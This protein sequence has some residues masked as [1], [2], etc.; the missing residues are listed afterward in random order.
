MAAEPPVGV[1]GT[2]ALGSVLANRL[3]AGG[4]PTC[5]YDADPGAYAA[6]APEVEP[7]PS[8]ADVARRAE[9]V[10]TC[11]TNAAAVEQAVLGPDGVVEGI[12]AG[13][14]LIET[15]TSTPATTRLLAGPLR[16]AGADLIDAPVSR[17][18][19]AALAGTLSIW[20]GGDAGTLRR[21]RPLLE[22]LGTDILHV[23]DLGAGHTVKAVNMLLMGINLA[24]LTEAA[25][26]ARRYGLELDR[27]LEVLN[28]S[29]GGSFMSASHFPRYVATGTY[30]SR[31]TLG[32]MLKDL[33]VGL[34]I[35]RD[36]GVPAPVAQRAAGL[37]ELAAAHGLADADNM[38]IVPFLES[39]LTGAP[40][41]E[42]T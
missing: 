30:D 20:V 31:F 7:L 41:E 14:V 9:F 16:A 17:G 13:S 26:L 27:F 4:H 22:R 36:L 18:V 21:C 39:L 5:A 38:R 1:I 23:G 29:S 28:T 34:D 11:V 40:L 24:A 10:L 42:A 35:A 25:T 8:P 33:R 19:P 15:T 2:G 6:L 3:A 12:R 32:L 37:W